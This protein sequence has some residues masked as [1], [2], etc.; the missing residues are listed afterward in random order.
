MFSNREKKKQHIM[1]QYQLRRD[2]TNIGNQIFEI[3]AHKINLSIYFMSVLTWTIIIKDYKVFEFWIQSTFKYDRSDESKY[4]IDGWIEPLYKNCDL[5]PKYRAKFV[6]VM[7][8][9]FFYKYNFKIYHISFKLR[10]Q[11]VKTDTFHEWC[12]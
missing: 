5:I 1:L 4:E 9:I 11:T 6:C 2:P 8:I 12:V 10:T 3:P 7:F